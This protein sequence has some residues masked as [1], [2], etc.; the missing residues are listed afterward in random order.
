MKE[1]TQGLAQT[2]EIAAGLA[3]DPV[4][5]AAPFAFAQFELL[6]LAGGGLGEFAELA[7]L[8][9]L[10]SIQTPPDEIKNALASFDSTS[11]WKS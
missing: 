10:A 1:P 9:T 7:G 8:G 11:V 6:D 4:L 2:A 5:L 3:A